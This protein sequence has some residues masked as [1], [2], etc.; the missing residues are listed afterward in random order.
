MS[1]ATSYLDP[2][3]LA[4]EELTEK[5]K[6][7]FKWASNHDLVLNLRRRSGGVAAEAQFQFQ[8][9]SGLEEDPEEENTID[10]PALSTAVID[11]VLGDYFGPLGVDVVNWMA[12][13]TVRVFLGINDNGIWPGPKEFD[14]H[15][16]AA[17]QTPGERNRL[18]PT[19]V[20]QTGIAAL[21]SMTFRR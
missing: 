12:P 10:L 3:C 19:W 8:I 16:L 21:V 2:D 9:E 5:H 7:L 13:N 6:E 14:D 11:P 17:S 4:S 18:E 1:D 20:Q 15:A